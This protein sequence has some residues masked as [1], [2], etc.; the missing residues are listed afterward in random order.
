MSQSIFGYVFD[1]FS[2]VIVGILLLAMLSLI[3]ARYAGRAVKTYRDS[4]DGVEWEEVK[5]TNDVVP[6]Q[7]KSR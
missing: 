1:I 2:M 4:R 6:Q 5:E 7:G 3:V